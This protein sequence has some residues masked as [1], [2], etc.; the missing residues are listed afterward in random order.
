MA[1][2]AMRGASGSSNPTSSTASCTAGNSGTARAGLD[3]NNT[4]YMIMSGTEGMNMNGA[5]ASA[6]AG[7]N[8]TKANW[9]YTGPALPTATANEL[10][11]RGKNGPTDIHMAESGCASRADLF[12]ADQR[13]PVR[14]GHQPGRRQVRRSRGRGG[15]GLCPGVPD[16][17]SR[18]V[19]REP[20]HRGGQCGRQA[21]TEPGPH[22]RPDLR[23]HTVRASGAGRSASTCCH[24]R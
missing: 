7:L 11:A 3:L 6:A 5:D 24:P 10:L 1:G 17:L 15:S 2:M 18:G 4:P 20:E 23:P 9:N 19:L 14:A 16:R 8:T 13:N 22:R 21:D 12:A